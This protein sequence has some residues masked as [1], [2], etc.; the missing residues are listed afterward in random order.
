MRTDHFVLLVFRT[1]P[2][3]EDT[4][5]FV[6]F[7]YNIDLAFLTDQNVLLLGS[8]IVL[9][10]L[11]FRFVYLRI[12]HKEQ[13]F[14]E[15][16]YIPRGLITILLFYKIPEWQRMDTFDEGVLFFV[17]LATGVIM[18][19]GSLLYRDRPVD[20]ADSPNIETSNNEIE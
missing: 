3:N 14:P 4:L 5:F 12:L 20:M 1:Q 11:L 15:L 2:A 7:G 9:A 10:L 19:I 13:L 17:I 18:M 8:S 16:L 6:I